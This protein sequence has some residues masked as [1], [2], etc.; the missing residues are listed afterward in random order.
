MDKVDKIL[1]VFLFS[2][3]SF[4]G[5]LSAQDMDFPFDTYL[6]TMRDIEISK[7]SPVVIDY[8]FLEGDELRLNLSTKKNK[9]IDKITIT[10]N[11][12]TLFTATDYDPTKQ[13]DID[14]AE[15]GVVEFTFSIRSFSQDIELRLMRKVKTDD[16]RFFNTALEI[17]KKYDTLSVPYEYNHV[18]GYAEH[19]EPIVFRSISD[20]DYESVEMSKKKYT[21]QGNQKNYVSITKPQDTIKTAN[22]EMVLTGYQILITSKA[23]ADAMWNAISTGVDIGC[24]AMSIFVP[25]GAAIGL[26]VETAFSMI[27]PQEGGEPVYYLIMGNKTELDK[28][29]DNDQNTNPMVYESG[30][31]TGY[32]GNWMPMDTMFIGLQNLNMLAEVE[33]SVATFAVYQATSWADINQDIVTIKPKVEIMTLNREVIAN[34]KKYVFQK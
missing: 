32:S 18:I 13:I 29:M 7:K 6:V 9:T 24:L 1:F 23:G 12:K 34:E 31:A 20:V 11:S 15:T 10:Q 28:F 26:G 3:T 2:I 5:F 19:R 14:I 8:T 21:L 17:Q 27:A 16:G 22:K 30:L 33:I 25:G 4:T